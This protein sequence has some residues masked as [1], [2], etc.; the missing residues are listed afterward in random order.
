MAHTYTNQKGIKAALSNTSDKGHTEYKDARQLQSDVVPALGLLSLDEVKRTHIIVLLDKK[1]K[2]EHFVARN[3][4]KAV[5][6]KYFSFVIE[7]GHIKSNPANGIQLIKEQSRKRVL[8]HNDILFLWQQTDE[9]SNLL[10]ATCLA[11]RFILITG[12]RPGEVRQ[13]HA[14]QIQ[15]DVWHMENTKN[16]HE[17]SIPLSEQALRV[18][19][20]AMPHTR[21]GLIFAG[22]NG[23]VMGINT[24]PRAMKRMT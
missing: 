13:L 24:L 1:E 23:N 18:I 7:R 9:N 5:L 17:H 16:G 6:S 8:S 20:Q 19:E 15:G 11:L 22:S 12:Q 10:P 21:H 4:L 2:A 14:S 3:R